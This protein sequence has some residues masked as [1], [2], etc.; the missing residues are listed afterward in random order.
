MHMAI[1]T[2]VGLALLAAFVATA[3]QRNMPMQTA[4]RNFVIVW[5][6]LAAIHFC[7]GVF[8]EGYPVTT[9]LAVHA[10]IFGVPALAAWFVGRG[11][12]GS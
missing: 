4:S 11:N 5:L 2:I 9:E 8:R 6:F 10:V 7:I 3:R 1:A 12:R